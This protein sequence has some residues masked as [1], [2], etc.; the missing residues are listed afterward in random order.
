MYEITHETN[1]LH[2]VVEISHDHSAYTI[3]FEKMT[4]TQVES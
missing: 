1:G 2:S 3:V 4:T